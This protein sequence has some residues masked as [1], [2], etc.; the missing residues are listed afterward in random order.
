MPLGVAVGAIVG[1]G[2]SIVGAIFVMYIRARRCK[3]NVLGYPAF[4]VIEGPVE[5]STQ[6]LVVKVFVP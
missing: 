2:D 5:L 1:N 4:Q 6:R 3:V